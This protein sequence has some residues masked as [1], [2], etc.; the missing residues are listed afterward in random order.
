MVEECDIIWCAETRDVGKHLTMSKVV[1]ELFLY[2]EMLGLK[3]K[4]LKKNR[5]RV[6]FPNVFFSLSTPTLAFLLTFRNTGVW[7]SHSIF[8]FFLLSLGNLP[9]RNLLLCFFP[10]LFKCCVSLSPSLITWSKLEC[11]HTLSLSSLYRTYYH[12][13]FS[14]WHLFTIS[15]H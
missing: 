11:P 7:R 5:C 13:I 9:L 12:L 10:S 1:S 4:H 2:K 3:Y 14:K 8:T 15:L 6:S